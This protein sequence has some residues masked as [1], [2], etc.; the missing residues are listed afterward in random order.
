MKRSPINTPTESS[1]PLDPNSN[2][3]ARGAGRELEYKYSPRKLYFPGPGI[4]VENFQ[5]HLGN[6]MHRERVEKRMEKSKE[7]SRH[8]L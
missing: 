6:R 2:A 3:K 5:V 8:H 4:G 1:T 7:R